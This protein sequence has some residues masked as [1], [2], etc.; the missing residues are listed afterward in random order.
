MFLFHY[1]TCLLLDY[2]FCAV[3]EVQ[4]QVVF[5]HILKHSESLIQEISEV[6]DCFKIT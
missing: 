4:G 6:I 5:K 1:R 2:I 3:W